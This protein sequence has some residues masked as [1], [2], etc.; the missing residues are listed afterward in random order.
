MQNNSEKKLENSK[1]HEENELAITKDK[2]S[3]HNKQLEVHEKKLA[4]ENDF[5]ANDHKGSYMSVCDLLIPY[6][7]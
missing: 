2:G 1:A 3:S 6:I 5:K 4:L 7:V